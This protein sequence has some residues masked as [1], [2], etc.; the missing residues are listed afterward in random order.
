MKIYRIAFAALMVFSLLFSK[1]FAQKNFAKD[2]DDA[3]KFYQ[4]YE[5]IDLYK[6]AYAKVKKDK[7]EKARIV[8]QIAECYRMTNDTK[9]AEVWYKKAVSA[10]YSDKIAVLDY[11]DMLK[12]NEKYE[13]AIVQYN[14]YA[15]LVPSD[16]RGAKGAESCTLSQ[17]WKDNPSRYEVENMKALNTKEMDFSPAYA[18]KKFK[19]LIFTSSREGSTGS[20][21]DAWTGQ[22]FTDLWLIA[23]DKKGSWST[24][25]S[26]GENINTKFNEG[27]SCLN[28]KMNELYFTRCG[29]EKKK[30]LGCQLFVAKKKN[31][32]WDVPDSLK[33]APD[34][35]SVGQP[36]LSE[37]ELTLYFAS[38][39]QGGYGGKDIWMAKRTKKNKEWDKPVNLGSNINTEKDEMYPFIREEG[40]LYFSSNGYS[41]MGGLDIY[42]SE[43]TDDKWGTPVN[44]KYPINSP[45]DDF[46]IIFEN[47][48]EKGYFSS[49]RKGGKGSDDIYSF[50]QPPLVF[51]L[52]GKICND[53]TKAMIKGA[54]VKLIG[55]DG[56]MVEYTSDATGLY[57]FD[58]TKFLPNTSYEIQVS[59]SNY[60]GK[61]GKE[62]TVGLERSKD[63]VHDLCITPIPAIPIV[64]P[65]ILYDFNKWDLLSQYQDSL[66]GLIQIMTDNPTIVVE[67]GSHTDARGSLEYNDSLSYKRAKSVVD[68]IITKGIAGDRI[69]A[70]GY[71]KRVPRTLTKDLTRDGFVFPKG[72]TLTE[73][74]INALK[75][76]DKKFEAAHQ[77]N[78]RTEFRVLRDNY[79][80]HAD[81]TTNI[82]APKIEVKTDEESINKEEKMQQQP[83]NNI[84][85]PDNNV[86][87]DEKTPAELKQDS[88]DNA[89]K[90]VKPIP[91]PKP[92]TNIKTTPKNTKKPVTKK[93]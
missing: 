39:M 80:P 81:T 90:V 23:Q 10:K 87:S 44:M 37:D 15:T 86:K 35:C 38:D 88:L 84:F 19:S 28:A 8:F 77:L 72:T 57:Q 91:T 65:E 6:K 59:K 32:S 9:Q 16:P 55:S 93:K 26:I 47:K 58:K 75:G 34:S 60:F 74:Y 78:R 20:D 85:T 52:Q 63:F 13:D 30:Q 22:S 14:A 89:K 53:S 69:E 82:V 25:V 33:L 71:S 61:K 31:T 62:S 1:S 68:Y 45:G 67:L 24:P 66:N 79:V 5:A 2:A 83:D 29:F 56:T 4:Y 40:I 7:A 54:L 43:K 48:L 51:T 36:S 12:I 17:Q 3:Y 18:D 11:A 21:Y 76:N 46:A 64:L 70:K 50:I 73:E 42:K 49:N 92:K 41:G 27:A